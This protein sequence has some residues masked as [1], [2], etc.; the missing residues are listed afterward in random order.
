MIAL[1]SPAK[2]LDFESKPLFDKMSMPEDLDLSEK[3]I[4]KLRRLSKKEIGKLMSI[5]DALA[6]L[7]FGRY[8]DWSTDFSTGTVK[9]AVMAF[10]GEVYRGLNASDFTPEDF[11]F[12][13]HH[14]FILSGLHGLLRPLDAIKPYR[15]EM[16]TKL[17]VGRKKN[18]YQFWGTHIAERINHLESDTII[19][20]AS[21]EYIKAADANHLKAQMIT[22]HFQDYKNGTYK[23]LM[24]Y[25][26]L[27][28]GAIASFMVKH[29]IEDPEKLKAFNWN[30]YSFNPDFGDETSWYFTRKQG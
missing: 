17:P 2:N 13:Q 20:L 14:L 24:A 22:C 21:N 5:S 11:D 25:A 1:I 30:G 7:N 15:L 12:A 19:N 4:K 26:K 6:E 10:N 29:R 18:L 8:Q 28:R 16:G 3:L 9:S 23:A 27:A